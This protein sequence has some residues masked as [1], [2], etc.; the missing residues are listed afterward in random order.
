MEFGQKNEGTA[1]RG[2]NYAVP[3]NNPVLQPGSV[4]CC[5]LDGLGTGLHPSPSS[6]NLDHLSGTAG[7][8]E[9]H[10]FIAATFQNL[11]L[12]RVFPVENFDATEFDFHQV[13]KCFE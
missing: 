4:K 10:Q 6:R 12:A 9:R 1:F 8:A 3:S 2:G 13:H 11:Y 7:A 5:E